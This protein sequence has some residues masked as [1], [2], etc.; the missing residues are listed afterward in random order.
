MARRI[1]IGRVQDFTPGKISEVEVEG[2]KLIVARDDEGVC[3]AHNKCPH[4][5]LSLTSGPGG[6]HFADGVIT[7]PWHNSRFVVRT[8]ENLDWVTGIAGRSVPSW[9][10][11]VIAAGRKPAPLATYPVVVEGD[12]VFVEI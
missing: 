5:G 12:N 7:C 10:R 9:S 6:R 2:T 11:K 4:L 8:G 3:A 1:R